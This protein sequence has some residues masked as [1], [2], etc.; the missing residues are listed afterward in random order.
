[1]ANRLD[2]HHVEYSLERKDNVESVIGKNGSINV[3]NGELILTGSGETLFRVKI[4][5]FNA[6]EFMSLNGVVITGYDLEHQQERTVI[7][8]YSYYRK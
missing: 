3:R 4:E 5:N 7:A 6:W 1:M 2:E 8:Y